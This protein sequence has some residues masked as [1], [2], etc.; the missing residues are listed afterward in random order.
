[1]FHSKF[2]ERGAYLRVLAS[3]RYLYVRLGIYRKIKITKYSG[4]S[5]L[6]L[7]DGMLDSNTTFIFTD[8]GSK[9]N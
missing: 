1:M 3:W 9:K 5:L 7:P 4:L 8:I 6:I 2:K